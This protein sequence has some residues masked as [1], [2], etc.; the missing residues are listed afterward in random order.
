MPLLGFGTYKVDKAD[1]VRYLHAIGTTGPCSYCVAFKLFNLHVLSQ[2]WKAD[3]GRY[4]LL[5]LSL[6][7]SCFDTRVPANRLRFVLQ[8]RKD[9]W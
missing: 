4:K 3:H 1:S 2:S 8:E 9:H 7:Q 5:S 6:L